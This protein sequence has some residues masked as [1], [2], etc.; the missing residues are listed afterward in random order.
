[1][2]GFR[3]WSR[4]VRSQNAHLADAGSP[5]SE[6][7]RLSRYALAA[8]EPDWGDRQA[9]ALPH[10]LDFLHWGLRPVRMLARHGVGILRRI[11]ALNTE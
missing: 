8:L 10:G 3:T 9:L 7:P 2:P 6:P 4:A 11:G 5:A 1:M